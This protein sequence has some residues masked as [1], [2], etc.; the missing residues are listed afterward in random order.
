MIMSD[1]LIPAKLEVNVGDRVVWMNHETK[2][3]VIMSGPLSSMMPAL[4][5]DETL[6]VTAAVEPASD[7][8][9]GLASTLQVE[10]AYIPTSVSRVMSLSERLDV[11]G[12]YIA[13]FVPT[14]PGDYRMR[15]F[16][17]IE[18]IAIDETFESGPDTFDTVVALDAI[19]FPVVLESSREIRNATR[20]ALD[21]IQELETDVRTTSSTASISLI[22]GMVGIGFGVIALAMSIF[23][24]TIARRRD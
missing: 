21:S 15:F 20:G 7:R 4:A 19:Q 8:V 13:E 10:V 1:R 12:H 3:I 2:N 11:P 14:A 18:G 23:A 6:G 16:G 17:S 5:D 24:I 9:T 22:V